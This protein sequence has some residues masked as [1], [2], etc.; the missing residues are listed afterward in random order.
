[1]SLPSING[2]ITI[3]LYDSNLIARLDSRDIDCIEIVY[4]HL[5]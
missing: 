1:M 5:I 4:C 3:A 2:K